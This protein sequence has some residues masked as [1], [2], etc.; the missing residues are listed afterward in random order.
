[1]LVLAFVVAFLVH[2]L[3]FSIAPMASILREAMHLSHA[4]FGLVF[5]VTMISLIL[6]RLPWGLLADRNGYVT[7]LR[8]ALLLSTAGAFFRVLAQGYHTF[9]ISQFL[10]GLGLA[11]TMPCLSLIVREWA[12][13]RPGMGTGTYVAGFAL[14]NAAALGLTPLLLRFF[15]YRQVLLFYAIGCAVVCF[16]WWVMARS[17]SAV[18]STI[19][20]ADFRAVLREKDMWILLLMLAAAMGCYD[21]LATWMPSVLE[22]KGFDASLAFLL[23]VGFV[24][25]GPVAGFLADRISNRKRLVCL[26]GVVATASIILLIAAPLPLLL[27]CLVLAGFASEG[28]LVVSLMVPVSDPR[29]SPYAGTVVGLTSSGANVGP[30]LMPVLFGYLIDVTGTFVMS[31]VSVAIL[32]A[33]VLVGVSRS[34]P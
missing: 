30:L 18:V 25:A 16:A 4:Q 21:T 34:M 6:F 3:L 19:R 12:P 24:A 14:G 29:L 33:V 17:R 26:L 28:V 15:Q 13:S 31:L 8:L 1:M 2:I 11:A 27:V 23:P 10:M 7:V 9:L 5:S 22:M 20:V 32:A